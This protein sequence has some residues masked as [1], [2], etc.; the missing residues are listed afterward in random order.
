MAH[1]FNSVCHIEARAS[2]L[3]VRL[4]K[5]LEADVAVEQS[6]HLILV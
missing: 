3:G 1:Q 2:W 5:R 4:I 6:I